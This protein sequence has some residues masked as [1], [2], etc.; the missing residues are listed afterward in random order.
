MRNVLRDSDVS[1]IALGFR[2]YCE[3]LYFI[4]ASK[5]DWWLF[6]LHKIKKKKK[7]GGTSL[8]P[9]GLKN[10]LP[11]NAG[12]VGSIPGSEDP[13]EKEMA[14]H[15]SILA[16]KFPWTEVHGVAKCQAWLSDWAITIAYLQKTKYMQIFY[17]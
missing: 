5:W 2:I 4:T 13:L 11:A 16:W 15:S 3:E 7:K 8:V 9:S 14:T 12:D 17:V 10:N 6:T 1:C